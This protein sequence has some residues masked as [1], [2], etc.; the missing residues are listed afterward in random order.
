MCKGER[1]R[2]FGKDLMKRDFFFFFTAQWTGDMTFYPDTSI[3]CYKKQ[4]TLVSKPRDS[5]TSRH[6]ARLP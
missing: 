2:C 5:C 6:F 1:F 3:S 4:W